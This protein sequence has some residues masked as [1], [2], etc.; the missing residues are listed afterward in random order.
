ML[1]LF[2][3]RHVININNPGKV[4][5]TGKVLYTDNL[6]Q[7]VQRIYG[8]EAKFTLCTQLSQQSIMG[9]NRKKSHL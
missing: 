9:K 1:I 2:M 6:E 4:N 5:I 3:Q 8:A 7:S